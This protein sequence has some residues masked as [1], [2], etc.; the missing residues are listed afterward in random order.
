MAIVAFGLEFTVALVAAVAVAVT[1]AKNLKNGNTLTNNGKKRRQNQP[2]NA[3]NGDQ[4]R[5]RRRL[6]ERW[7]PGA[8]TGTIRYQIFG[9][10]GRHLVD[11]RRFWGPLKIMKKTE[12]THKKPQFL[13]SKNR[14]F[15]ERFLKRFL[16]RFL[17]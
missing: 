13:E 16:D 1:M 5:S 2:P 10:F 14:Y 11:F 9:A 15:L 7:D 6:C 4:K 8:V 3:P 12:K 17:D